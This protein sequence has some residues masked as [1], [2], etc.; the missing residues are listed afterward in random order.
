MVL[1]DGEV[2]NQKYL[3]SPVDEKT[4]YSLMQSLECE[5]LVSTSNFIR[6]S[7][8]RGIQYTH[9][10]THLSLREHKFRSNRTDPT[11]WILC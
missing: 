4:I 9:T 11:G 8:M 2:T 1:T 7:E 10:H 6:M 3:L 5:Q